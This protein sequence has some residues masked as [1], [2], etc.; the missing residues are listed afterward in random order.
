MNSEYSI[1][2]ELGKK[3]LMLGEK[4]TVLP[5]SPK[6]YIFQCVSGGRGG[7]WRERHFFHQLNIFAERNHATFC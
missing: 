6:S 1:L 4:L 2:K 3:T 7:I 5:I